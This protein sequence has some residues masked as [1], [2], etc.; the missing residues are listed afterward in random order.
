MSDVEYVIECLV[1][2]KTKARNIKAF[3]LTCLYNAKTYRNIYVAN[4][5]SSNM[6]QEKNDLTAVANAAS[7][8]EKE[9]ISEELSSDYREVLRVMGML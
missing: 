4:W 9:E 1:N 6:Y 7:E 5:V 8:I 2:S 3:M